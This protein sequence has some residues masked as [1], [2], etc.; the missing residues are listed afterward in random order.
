LD[1]PGKREKLMARLKP[2]PDENEG[3]AALNED[4]VLKA[5]ALH[6]N[7][8]RKSK[9]ARLKGRRPFDSAQDKPLQNQG[10]DAGLKNPALRL[11]LGRKPREA[12][13]KAPSG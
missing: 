3:K 1:T 11:S 6:L 5:A 4:A 2:C 13:L 12:R 9:E 7:L 10:K 8:N